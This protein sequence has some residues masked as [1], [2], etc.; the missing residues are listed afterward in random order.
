MATIGIRD[1][2]HSINYLPVKKV[3]MKFDISGDLKDE[4]ITDSHPA[5]NGNCNIFEITNIPFNVPLDLDY[6][7][8]LTVFA[9][10][11]L[12]GFL[13]QRLVGVANIPLKPYCEKVLK[14][15]EVT[16]KAF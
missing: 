12:M 8:V 6:A 7:P 2:I 13:G 1:L 5:K 4:I 11:N 16:A 3:S 14:K 15:L 10:D 9:Y